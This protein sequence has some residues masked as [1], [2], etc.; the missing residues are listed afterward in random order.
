MDPQRYI[1]VYESKVSYYS[2]LG[3]LIVAYDIKHNSWHCPCN[4]TKHSCT[5]KA[6]AK[7][8]L[9]VTDRQLFRRVK[10]TEE[11][12]VTPLSEPT[13]EGNYPPRYP[14]CDKGVENMVKY[15]LEH[16]K[17]PAELPE[18]IIQQT[19]G[20]LPTILMPFPSV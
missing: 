19:R 17:R 1:S 13:V 3:R 20:K 5:H 11:T 8:H 9:F 4:K 12:E 15:L 7:W 14:P 6:I 2:R 16:K 10:T 18:E